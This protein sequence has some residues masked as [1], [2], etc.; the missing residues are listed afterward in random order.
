MQSNT[1]ED[2][3]RIA[4]G[5]KEE[6]KYSSIDMVHRLNKDIPMRL[7]IK[8]NTFSLYVCAVARSTATFASTM[9]I[10]PRLRATP[11]DFLA[12][13]IHALARASWEKGKLRPAQAT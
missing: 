3:T 13:M 11:F 6:G 1:S 12:G 10:E 8:R 7:G 2:D 9:S 4:C 5:S